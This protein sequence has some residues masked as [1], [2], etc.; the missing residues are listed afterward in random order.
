[1]TSLLRRSEAEVHC[2]GLHIYVVKMFVVS[3]KLRSV[4]TLGEREGTQEFLGTG[5]VLSDLGSGYLVSTL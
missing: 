5:T 4:V 1:M 3:T 2:L